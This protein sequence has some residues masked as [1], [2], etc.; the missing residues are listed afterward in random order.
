MQKTGHRMRAHRNIL[1]ALAMSASVLML[2]PNVLA[3]DAAIPPTPSPVSAPIARTNVHEAGFRAYLLQVRQRALGEGV[4]TATLDHVLP[5]LSFN[6]T[7]VRLDKQ[8]P[9]SASNAPVPN[10]APY[11]A[12]HVDASR[13]GRGRFKYAELRP[14][15]ERIEKETGVPEE[16]MIAI[17]GHETSYGAVTGNFNAPEALASLAYEGRRR[18]LFEAELVAV[19]KMIDRGVPQ[20]A[21]TGSWAGALGKP[22]FLPS[23]YLRL[24]RDGDGDGYADIWRSEVDAMMS[25]ANYFVNAGWRR[26]EEWGFAV[27]VPVILNRDKLGSRMSPPRCPRVFGRHSQWRTIAE[28]RQLGI[29]PQSGSWPK[30]SMMATLLE[31]DGAGKTGYLLG[32]N[33]RVILDYNCSNFYAL[34]VGLLA[35][36][37]RN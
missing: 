8:Q 6:R 22:Q 33:Y 4:S 12:T 31:P 14:L 9:E 10:F 25:I 24:A 32:G 1:T 17:Y 19:L 30:D 7:V 15:L 5:S 29:S 35:D 3:Q 28:W 37:L 20:Y 23:V 16:I 36:Q 2:S 21:I 26:G 11:K 34:S 18:P 13:I 27:N